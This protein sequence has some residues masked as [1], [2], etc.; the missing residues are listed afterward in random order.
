MSSIFCNHIYKCKNRDWCAGEFNP[1]SEK[2]ECFRPLTNADLIRT[3]T[4]DE[5]AEFLEGAYGNMLPNT[6]LD[7][8]KQEVDT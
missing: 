5:L 4:D 3:M 6:A 8:L 7:W 1:K 2:P